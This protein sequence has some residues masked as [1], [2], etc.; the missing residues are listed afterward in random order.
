MPGEGGVC[1]AVVVAG[2]LVVLAVFGAI[3]VAGTVAV[4]VA[5]LLGAM[6]VGGVAGFEAVVVVAGFVAV[7]AVTGLA[8]MVVV[9]G[10]EVVAAV[11]PVAV[12]VVLP[13]VEAV[14]PVVGLVVFDVFGLGVLLE[15]VEEVEPLPVLCANNAPEL[16]VPMSR[17]PSTMETTSFL[18]L[19]FILSPY[20]SAINGRKRISGWVR[21]GSHPGADA[22]R[23]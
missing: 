11:L 21:L 3:V 2:L 20:D 17:A 8:A 15:L 14:A 19:P 6:A 4:V 16:T 7:I 22:T 5:G 1:D 13:V 12:V 10:F 18:T 23:K 9:A